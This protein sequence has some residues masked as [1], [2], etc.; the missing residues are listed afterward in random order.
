[1]SVSKESHEVKICSVNN[2]NSDNNTMLLF[3][4]REHWLARK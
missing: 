1:M 2:L 3:G 4:I